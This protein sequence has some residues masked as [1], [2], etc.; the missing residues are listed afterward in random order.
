MRREAIKK[1]KALDSLKRYEMVL[2]EEE[3]VSKE[4]KLENFY[5]EQQL[6]LEELKRRIHKHKNPKTHTQPTDLVWAGDKTMRESRD[7]AVQWSKRKI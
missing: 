4:F 2:Q 5:S 3:S 7:I 6:N 1:Q